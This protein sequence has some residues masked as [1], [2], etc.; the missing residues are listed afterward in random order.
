MHLL[1]EHEHDLVSLLQLVFVEPTVFLLLL[2]DLFLG[3]E[4]NVILLHIVDVLEA[5]KTLVDV[6][7]GCRQLLHLLELLP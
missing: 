7:V 5:L 2:R 6:E 1:I 4:G 3:V